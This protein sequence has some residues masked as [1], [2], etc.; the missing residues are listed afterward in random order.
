MSY[1]VAELEK[2]RLKN[3]KIPDHVLLKMLL[4]IDRELVKEEV[5][6]S[7]RH[8]EG[9]QRLQKRLDTIVTNIDPLWVKISVFFRE[10]YPLKDHI[11]LPMHRG[12]FYFQGV[13]YELSTGFFVGNF[14]IDILNFIK[15]ISAI[16]IQ[17][18]KTSNDFG[19]YID[20][21]CD[22]LDV[23]FGIE[24]LKKD[25]SFSKDSQD[26]IFSGKSQLNSMTETLLSM[27]D[28]RDASMSNA[29]LGT[30]MFLKGG[31]V[32]K[33]LSLKQVKKLS[34]NLDNI[35]ET[36]R[37]TFPESDITRL[38]RAVANIP[39]DVNLRYKM[40]NYTKRV[41]GHAGMSSQFCAG[42]VIRLLTSQN[43]RNGLKIDG[44]NS[45]I[46]RAYP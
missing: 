42:E 44:N 26:F 4:E 36:F 30:E 39:K 22:L 1:T 15:G 46:S 40:N 3:S 13:I 2:F 10:I 24:E 27:T 38:S 6:V 9:I 32:Y 43:A 20:Q 14:N 21:C 23:Y 17:Q 7:R 34:H 8:L 11:L 33:G 16:K 31:L 12:V 41:M 18:L 28:D 25:N 19:V 29:L 5:P 37:K 35:L 45:S